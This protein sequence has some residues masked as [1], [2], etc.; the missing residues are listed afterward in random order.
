M[1]QLTSLDGLILLSHPAPHIIYVLLY[2]ELFRS[3]N[4]FHAFPPFNAF[5]LIVF[6]LLL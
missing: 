5:T 1:A 2:L 6:Q 3:V 4:I